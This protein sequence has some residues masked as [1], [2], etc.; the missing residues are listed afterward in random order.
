LV[1]VEFESTIRL[2]A[3]KLG[4]ELC[5][6]QKDMKQCPI[7]HGAQPSWERILGIIKKI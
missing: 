3:L 5:Y 1:V 4:K 7:R 6:A 2:A